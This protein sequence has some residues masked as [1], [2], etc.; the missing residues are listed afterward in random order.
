[1]TNT[2]SESGLLKHEE[3]LEN[4]PIPAVQHMPLSVNVPNPHPGKIYLSE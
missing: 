4:A 3:D 2:N 1:M